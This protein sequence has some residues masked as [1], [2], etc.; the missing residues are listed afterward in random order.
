MKASFKMSDEG[1]VLVI[2]PNNTEE[3]DRVEWWIQD[4]GLGEFIKLESSPEV[5]YAL[6]E[7]L[8]GDG[9]VGGRKT[10]TAVSF[11]PD[12][13]EAQRWMQSADNR[14]YKLLARS[15]PL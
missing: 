9:G 8:P 13:G 12:I 11:T 10:S 1:F 2:V 5:V 4:A 3:R 7:W 6:I 15:L 14:N